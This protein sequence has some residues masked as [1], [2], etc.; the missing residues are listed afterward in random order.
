MFG[1]NFS[2]N[3]FLNFQAL[4]SPS[5][6]AQLVERQTQNFMKSESGVRILMGICNFDWYFPLFAFKQASKFSIFKAKSVGH[7]FQYFYENRII[8]TYPIARHYKNGQNKIH[9]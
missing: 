4:I 8:M 2:D 6:V 1:E 9:T 7:I 5:P 3:Y